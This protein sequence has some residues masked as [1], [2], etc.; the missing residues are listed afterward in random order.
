MIRGALQHFPH[1]WLMVVGLMLFLLVF[2]G[3]IVWVFHPR[4]RA[5]HAYLQALPLDEDKVG[6][7]CH[8]K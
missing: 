3:V 1:P 6:D 8:E 4:A 2:V 5:L 7:S